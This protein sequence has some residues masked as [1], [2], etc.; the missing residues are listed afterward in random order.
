MVGGV[1]KR[2]SDLSV[3]LGVGGTVIVSG[4]CTH[5]S[6]S[7]HDSCDGW[8]CD[9]GTVDVSSTFGLIRGSGTFTEVIPTFVLV[10][11]IHL[12]KQYRV[13][14]HFLSVSSSSRHEAMVG[15]T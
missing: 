5:P 2:A 1:L 12:G 6:S 8:V 4:S 15:D 3:G 9:L 11:R 10:S 7:S 13:N 14:D